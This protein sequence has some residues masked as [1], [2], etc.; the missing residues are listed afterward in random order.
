MATEKKSLQELK[1]LSLKVPVLSSKTV[2]TKEDLSLVIKAYFQE[3]INENRPP[4]MSG[5]AMTLGT[6]RHELITAEHNNPEFQTILQLAR[7]T[8]IEYVEELLIAG[9]PPQGLIFWL[10][11]ND[12]WIDRTEVVKGTKT[13]AEVLKDLE[14]DGQL[15]NASNP[16]NNMQPQISKPKE[17]ETKDA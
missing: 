15:K 10:K 12:Q 4:T 13:M 3:C 9:K 1:I 14:M 5:L 6:T 7:Q 8:I 2:L 17:P 11:N 16:L